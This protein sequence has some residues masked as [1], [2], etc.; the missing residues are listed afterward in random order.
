M[1]LEA[2]SSG[3]ESCARLDQSHFAHVRTYRL[4]EFVVS[5]R[6]SGGKAPA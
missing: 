1:N 3:S 5:S 2:G 6:T 4:L